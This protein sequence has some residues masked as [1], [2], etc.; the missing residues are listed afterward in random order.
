MNWKTSSLTGNLLDDTR[1]NSLPCK[2]DSRQ[3]PDCTIKLFTDN[4]VVDAPRRWIHQHRHWRVT[5]LM[6]PERTLYRINTNHDQQQIVRVEL[7]IA[8]IIS[9]TL[10][11]RTLN[12]IQ[13]RVTC[14][15][16]PKRTLY[17]A[18]TNHEQQQLVR[19]GLRIHKI[20]FDILRWWIYNIVK[21][22]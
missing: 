17:R 22:G 19:I 6:I 14:L 18:N 8:N 20:I 2:C 12:H 21:D 16:I 4:I 13:G 7:R 3:R 15:T 11:R 9:D 5:C 10:R 1:E